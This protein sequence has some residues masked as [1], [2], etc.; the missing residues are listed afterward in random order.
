MKCETCIRRFLELDDYSRVPLLLR[1]H[2]LRCPACRAEM[3]RLAKTFAEIACAD[4]CGNKYDAADAIMTRIRL[5]G[6]SY[7]KRV[8]MYNW[9]GVGILMVGGMFLL[10]F[11]DSLMWL[12][13][14]FG[15]TIEVPLNLV[16]GVAI[17]LYAAAFVATHMV[18]R[19]AVDGAN[20]PGPSSFPTRYP[21]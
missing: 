16:M 3:D 8:P 10:N 7:G 2:A 9:I 15:G 5:S 1:L 21:R 13:S 11:S 18:P 4:S 17:T 14:Q 6:V 20:A 12:K 19:R